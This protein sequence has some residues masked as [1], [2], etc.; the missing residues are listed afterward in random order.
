ME[1][2]QGTEQPGG[3]LP[4]PSGEPGGHRGL[5]CGEGRGGGAASRLQQGRRG[6]QGARMPV[7]LGG[8]PG[9]VPGLGVAERPL[10][11]L[12]EQ[13]ER[14]AHRQTADPA[15]S[16]TGPRFR[17]TVLGRGGQHVTAG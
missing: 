5:V 7:H 2:T 13:G 17:R 14:S 4:E 10:E 9:G 3:L 16:D 12:F 1:G 15:G 11:F 6:D 8:E